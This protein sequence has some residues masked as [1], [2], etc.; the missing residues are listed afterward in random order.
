MM[1]SVTML[2]VIQAQKRE[3]VAV[4]RKPPAPIALKFAEEELVDSELTAV[5]TLRNHSAVKLRNRSLSLG[6]KVAVARSGQRRRLLSHGRAVRF[7]RLKRSIS[8][9]STTSTAAPV[10]P[11]SEIPTPTLQTPDKSLPSAPKKMRAGVFEQSW[12][13]T[14]ADNSA[15]TP[16]TTEVC[17]ESTP[18]AEDDGSVKASARLSPQDPI[19]IASTDET[20]FMADVEDLDNRRD[21]SPLANDVRCLL[22]SPLLTQC[23]EIYQIDYRQIYNIDAFLDRHKCFRS[24]TSRWSK[25]CIQYSMCHSDLRVSR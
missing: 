16:S 2:N 21:S 25:M 8:T 9:P 24:S 6:P 13:D 19:M 18:A 11:P 7:I 14:L 20:V 3:E 4:E 1:V 17:S 5:K 10:S 12:T 22:F 23:L 15:M